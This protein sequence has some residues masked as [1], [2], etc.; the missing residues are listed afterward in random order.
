[1]SI[2]V[3]HLN[4][5]FGRFHAVQDAS[6]QLGSGEL[7]ALLGPSGSG[8]STILRMIAGLET[9]DSGSIKLKGEEATHLS[10]KER[11][12]GFVFQHYAL[13]RHMNVFE[14]IAFGLRV[15][16]S[17]KKLIDSRVSELLHL[18]Q[19]QG[20][21]HRYPHQLSGGQR[22]RVALARSLAPQPKVLLLDEPF[23]ALDAKVREEL[24]TWIRQLHKES[25]LTTLFVTHDQNEA[26]EIA[27]K[28]LVI[29][30]GRIEQE[31][32]PEDIF[33]RPRTD[34]VAQFVGDTNFLDSV[35]SEPELVQW[36]PFRFTVDSKFKRG[37][38]VRI[39][40]RPSD[41]YVTSV[42]ETLQ[43][44]AQIHAIHF[45]GATIEIVLEIEAGRHVIAHLPKG[46]AQ[47]GK[48]Y[49]G[50]KVFVGITAY[51]VFGQ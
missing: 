35:V 1:M 32:S 24:R 50:Q 48:Y 19:L 34:F 15:R 37:Q 7:V 14:N 9:P 45:R 30:Q 2:E 42:P 6:F 27:S 12:I 5:S 47:A 8:K 23:G 3:N 44:E 20:L 13:F 17:E 26:L 36:G 16:K 4:K 49:L 11:N 21:E 10:A 28:I 40:F 29:H 25:Q 41:V 43:V 51:H 38:K 46:V 39:Y 18:V 33:D 31:G 22:Q